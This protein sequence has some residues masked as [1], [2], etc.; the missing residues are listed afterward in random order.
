MY[1]QVPVRRGLGET[2][3]PFEGTFTGKLTGDAGT[4]TAITASFTHRDNTISG[5]IALAP[6]LQLQFGKP[7][8]LEPVDLKEIPISTV[9]DAS[10]PNHAEA[11]T[12]VEEPTD[13]FPFIKSINIKVTIVANLEGK[14]MNG[15]VTL[16]PQGVAK[17]CGARTLPVQLTKTT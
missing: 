8:T 4:S 15:S 3:G 16:A 12:T 2:V 11:T 7:C 5:K 1:I 17:L 9:W 6:G 13:Q 14:A 10:K